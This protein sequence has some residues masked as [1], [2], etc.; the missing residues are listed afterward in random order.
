MT[1]V[2]VAPAHHP[3]AAPQAP[4]RT[5]PF[6]AR[7]AG[8]GNR[9]AVVQD[10]VAVT[11]VELARRTAE[12]ARRLGPRRR[13]VAI[14][15]GR[16]LGTLVSYLGALAGGHAVLLASDGEQV[17][18]EVLRTYEPDVVLRGA[19]DDWRL[20]ERHPGPVHELHP[21][22][23]LLLSTSGST[24]SPKLVRLSHGNLQANAEAVAESLG[25]REDDRAVTTLP[26]HYCYGLSVVHSHLLRGATLVLTARSVVDACFWDLVRDQQVTCF[27]GVPHTFDLLERVGFSRM[28]LPHLRY[29][30]QA[31]GRLGPEKV[32]HWSHVGRQ[33]GWDLVVMYGQTEATAR[34][35]YL[36]PDLAEARPG[37]IG[38]PV[39]GGAFR[40][41]PV[42]ESGAVESREPAGPDVGELVYTGPNV[43]LGYASSPADLGLGRTVHE[44]RTGDLGRR[45][46]DGLYEVVG[47]RSRFVKPFGLRVDLGRVEERLAAEHG[48]VA[49]C[50]GTDSGLAVAVEG[51]ADPARVRTAV[52]AI[53]TGLPVRAVQVHAVDALPRTCSGKPDLRAVQAMAAGGPAPA[54]GAEH[55]VDRSGPVDQPGEPIRQPG[56]ADPARLRDLYAE[57]L[58]RPDATEDH[59]FVDLGGDSLSYVEVSVRLEE[60]LGHLPA[61]WHT[62]PVRDLAPAARPDRAGRPGRVVETSVLLRAVGIVLVVGTHAGLFTL[63]GSA[64]VLVALAGFNFARFQLTAAPRAERVRHQLTSVARVVVPSVAWIAGALLLTDL[65]SPA[66]LLLLNAVVG[67]DSWTTQ[68]HFWFVE[69]LVWLLLLAAALTAVPWADRLERRFPFGFTA[70]PLGV[71]LLARFDVV[72][73]GIGPLHL[74]TRPVLWLF[75]LGWAAARARTVPQRLLVTAVAAA[76]VP[77]FFDDPRR[78]AL[79]VAGIA[80][81]VWAPGIRCPAGVARAAAV[82]AAASLHVYLTHWAVYP[83]LADRSPLLA[84]LASLAA[85][86]AYWAVATPAVAAAERA[87]E[88]RRVRAARPG[89]GR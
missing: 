72:S 29:V 22:L 28:H 25:I 30:T 73:L 76:S 20:E 68:W 86:V 17:P 32:R 34:M 23:T 38:V 51:G 10:G 19:H 61:G 47:R 42:T 49:C 48:L 70:L 55:P 39:P 41:E 50:V 81:L 21:D 88:R 27:A 64:H 71:G 57:L 44:L 14:S 15:G 80:L 67:P 74:H 6:V 26:W 11:Y 4:A 7:L 87:L 40:V 12:V 46:D 24:G 35:A 13:L 54:A 89:R 37:A 65:Y 5:V 36:P 53:C 66:N 56:R 82:L 60:L 79:M 59:S 69:V 3:G 8:H 58:G 75:A 77:G 45:A 52:A 18:A 78:E 31:G 85:G 16:D 83:H 33:G 62:L 2:P 63:L 84:V 43:M 9:P 1:A